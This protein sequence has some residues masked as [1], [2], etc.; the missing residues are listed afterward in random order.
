MALRFLTIAMFLASPAT[1][2][3][4]EESSSPDPSTSTTTTTTTTTTT[5]DTTTTTT[6]STTTTTTTTQETSTA[7]ATTTTTTAATT[8]VANVTTTGA[9]GPNVTATGAAGTGAAG[10]GNMGAGSMGEM[11]GMMTE[12]QAVLKGAEI[13]ECPDTA[14]SSSS[15]GTTPDPCAAFPDAKAACEED[16]KKAKEAA[17][18]PQ[19]FC[20]SKSGDSKTACLDSIQALANCVPKGAATTV[21][22][23]SDVSQDVKVSDVTVYCAAFSNAGVTLAKREAWVTICNKALESDE[24]SKVILSEV[25]R[26]AGTC[27][28]AGGRRARVLQDKTA[29][30]NDKYTVKQKI[31]TK[32]SANALKASLAKVKTFVSSDA[33]KTAITAET[34]SDKVKNAL[35]AAAPALTVGDATTKAVTAKDPA[36]KNAK[37]EDTTFPTATAS[38]S[39]GLA[40]SIVA[41]SFAALFM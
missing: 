22:Q 23:E 16:L 19:A 21:T 26:A 27:A 11:S 13:T 31:T 6:T 37:G 35:K 7:A 28:A 25:G 14:A 5:A 33:G 32:R 34:N 2:T 1:A 4:E 24:V 41:A 39:Q 40:G 29:S 36:A 8:T 12:A 38:S 10:E 30:T 18:N 15:P 3:A 20:D 17:A 9:A